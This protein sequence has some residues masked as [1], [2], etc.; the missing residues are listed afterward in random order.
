MVF[1][2]TSELTQFYKHLY[3][4]NFVICYLAYLS[5]RVSFGEIH[6][7]YVGSNPALEQKIFMHWFFRH[8]ATF[9]RIIICSKGTPFLKKGFGLKKRFLNLEGLL[10]DFSAFFPVREI[11]NIFFRKL[12]F[13]SPG[14]EKA[15][16]ESYGYPLGYFLEL[17]I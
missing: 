16:F 15:L 13:L 7:V 8:C 17:Y 6:C 3:K 2:K 9:L 1:S 14:M 4:F 11:F 5:T 12:G 10:S